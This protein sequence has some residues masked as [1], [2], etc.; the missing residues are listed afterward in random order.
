[1]YVLCITTLMNSRTNQLIDLFVLLKLEL[2]IALNVKRDF[3]SQNKYLRQLILGVRIIFISRHVLMS[4]RD[5]F[6]RH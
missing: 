4:V 3:F 5:S 6:H 1:M 2:F